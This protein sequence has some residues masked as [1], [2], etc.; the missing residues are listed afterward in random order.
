M[1]NEKVTASK[2]K[3]QKQKDQKAKVIAK[4]VKFKDVFAKSMINNYED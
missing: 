3:T 1:T 4:L 2:Q